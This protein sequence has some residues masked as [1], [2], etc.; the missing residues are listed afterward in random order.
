[1]RMRKRK[2]SVQEQAN[3]LKLIGELLERG[4]PLSEAISSLTFQLHRQRKE[5]LAFCIQ[6]LK[7]GYSFSD[8]LSMLKFK[9]DLIGYVFF[10]ERHGGFIQA[11]KDGSDVMLNR[12]KDIDRLM[13]LLFYPLILIT[14]TLIL[15]IVV[16]KMLLPRFTSLFY[17][18]QIEANFFTKVLITTAKMLPLFLSTIVIAVVSLAGYH[19]FYFRKYSP[20]TQRKLLVKIPLLGA[21]LRLLYTHYFSAQLSYLLSGGLSMNE[22]L[23]LFEKNHDQPFY[24]QI[25]R[26][27]KKDLVGGKQLE[28]VMRRFPFFEKDLGK[29]VLHGQKNGRLDKELFF[30]SRHCLWRL[31][32]KTEKWLKIIQPLLY[33]V[34][35]LLIVSMYLAV[36]LPM[37]KLLD[38][39]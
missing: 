37:F 31:E 29:V 10:A 16:D 6:S 28:I 33:T 12:R 22:A 18:L 27:M 35:G 3:F 21:M 5:D 15:F 17:S 36:L 34:V 20:L 1:M 4:Y 13:K 24:Q 26:E 25:G 2:W 38:G 23:Q 9:D 11:L 19:F 14:F 32:E 30:Y 8:I 39:F 7:E